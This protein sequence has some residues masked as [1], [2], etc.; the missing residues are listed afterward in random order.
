MRSLRDDQG[1]T[2]AEVVIAAAILFFVL[3]ALLGLIGA[4][5]TLGMTSKQK[6]ALTNIM[7]GRMDWV[8]SLPFDQVGLVGTGNGKIPATEDSIEIGDGSFSVTLTY[9]VRLKP[10]GTKDVTINGL[11]T[12]GNLNPLTITQTF[13]VTDWTQTLT[14]EEQSGNG[15]KIKI[16]TTTSGGLTPTTDSVLYGSWVWG[17]VPQNIVIDAKATAASGTTISRIEY[18]FTCENGVSGL[19][20]NGP[21]TGAAFARW[22]QN[23]NDPPLDEAIRRES[24]YWNT[25]Q[26]DPAVAD[27][28]VNVYVTC[29]D[30]QSRSASDMIR[31]RVDNSKPNPPENFTAD[32]RT[33]R[34]QLS[35]LQPSSGAMPD[36]YQYQLL[37]EP[38]TLQSNVANWTPVWSGFQTTT[39]ISAIFT[40]NADTVYS[41][42][43]RYSGWVRSASPVLNLS[44]ETWLTSPFVTRPVQTGTSALVLK[45]DGKSQKVYTVTTDLSLYQPTFPCTWS[46]VVKTRAAGSTGAWVNATGV[47]VVSTTGG[48][49]KLRLA[50]DYTSNKAQGKWSTIPSNEYLIETTYSTTNVKSQSGTMNTNILGPTPT[51]EVSVGTYTLA[52]R[53]E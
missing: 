45:T 40:N 5:T 31:F 2:V 15:P 7:G 20:R 36:K 1:M 52:T 37:K 6:Q 48:I 23:P 50:N 4:S 10:D 21:D 22:P 42:F 11:C 53:W 29:W 30:D 24:F 34:T 35:W 9:S 46:N 51:N 49:T 47:T 16:L 25:K 26:I 19:L 8:R 44:D 3:T 33:D 13:G 18:T 43:S 41:P 17:T 32:V 12:G 28:M 14:N 27:G 39:S 38:S